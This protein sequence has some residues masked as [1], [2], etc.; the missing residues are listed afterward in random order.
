M[1]WM[2]YRSAALMIALSVGLG[3]CVHDL[4][5]TP[6]I[7]YRSQAE[8]DAALAQFDHDNPRCELWTNWQKACVRGEDGTALC[9]TDANHR[10]RAST[11]FC[12]GAAE[13]IGGANGT[14]LPIN[15]REIMHSISRFCS[16]N[17]DLRRDSPISANNSGFFTPG[18]FCDFSNNRPFFVPFNELNGNFRNFVPVRNSASYPRRYS[19]RDFLTGMPNWCD[20]SGD[21]SRSEQFSQEDNSGEIL[22]LGRGD[23]LRPLS[24]RYCRMRKAR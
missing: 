21:P 23:G 16:R 15:S 14:L 18:G 4:A 11:P 20:V 1:T 17:F 12:A 9:F 22:L 10:A 8:A 6:D 7:Y 24:L 2:P 3:A 19:Y 5:E 13:G